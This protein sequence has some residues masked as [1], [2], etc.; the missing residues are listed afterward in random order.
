MKKYLILYSIS[1]LFIHCTTQQSLSKKESDTTTKI[2]YDTL[3][4][5]K[6]SAVF[7]FP[8]KL[9][10]NSGIQIIDEFIWT[11]N[12]S[13]GENVIYKTDFKGTIVQEVTIGNAKNNDWE[14]IAHDEKAFYIGDF[15]NNNG[16]R[17]DLTIY[18]IMKSDITQDPFQ[19]V[20]AEKIIFEYSDRTDFSKAPYQHDFDCESMFVYKNQIHLL[21]K[22]WKTGVSGHYVLP[23]QPGKYKAQFL[24][25]FDVHGFLTAVDRENEH[26]A[27]V[28][29]D[30]D[31]KL[32]LWDFSLDKN[33]LLF[34]NPI[35]STY[36][37]N[38]SRWGQ[39]EGLT[40]FNNKLYISGE[41]MNEIAPT[42][43]LIQK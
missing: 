40:F 18:K 26:V 36:L 35:H 38:T 1:F 30:R 9:N 31:G 4:P 34:N 41:E 14:E 43:Y 3:A 27:A 2:L 39:I 28:Q 33:G 25:K 23:T 12:D 11:F 24:E 32:I 20:T 16:N 7:S 15:G 17:Q 6:I 37:G 21:T 29:Y 22:A 19:T 5:E 42:F 10:E 8:Q 13:G